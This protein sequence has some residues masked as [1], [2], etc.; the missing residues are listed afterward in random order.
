MN[1]SL[2]P[3]KAQA[4]LF[5]DISVREIAYAIGKMFMFL[6]TLDLTLLY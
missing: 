4:E 5:T 1:Q 2:I 3:H 6:T